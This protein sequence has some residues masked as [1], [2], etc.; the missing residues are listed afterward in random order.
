[1]HFVAR[2]SPKGVCGPSRWC[3]NF[4]SDL[5]EPSSQIQVSVAFGLSL[6]NSFINRTRIFASDVASTSVRCYDPAFASDTPYL[7]GCVTA[8]H[9][10]KVLVT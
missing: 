4:A 5:Y 7:S 1:M 3:L 9:P 6:Q 8:I 2:Q 10:A